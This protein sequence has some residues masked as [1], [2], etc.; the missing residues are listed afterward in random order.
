M[1]GFIGLLSASP[2]GKPDWESE[3]RRAAEEAE[4]QLRPAAER[5]PLPESLTRWAPSLEQLEKLS[6]ALMSPAALVSLISQPELRTAA[7]HVTSVVVELCRRAE[8]SL[9]ARAGALGAEALEEAGSQVVRWRDVAWRLERD[10]LPNL[11]KVQGLVAAGAAGAASRKALLEASRMNVLLNNLDRLEVRGRDSAGL[12]LLVTFPDAEQLAHFEGGLG[13]ALREE[14]HRRCSLQDFIGGAVVRAAGSPS[15]SASLGFTLKVAREVGALGD[16]VAELRTQIRQDSL[17]WSALAHPRTHLNPLAHTR[18]ASNGVI[19][20]ANC[21]PQDNAV[22]SPDGAVVFAGGVPLVAAVLNGDLDNFQQL[23]RT[24]EQETGLSLPPSSTTDAKLIPVMVAHYLEQAGGDLAEAFRRAVGRFEGS[25]AIALHSALEPRKVYLALR[26][27][28]QALFVG[29]SPEGLLYASELYGLVEQTPR[30][31]K[32]EG[33]RVPDSGDR[34]LQGEVAVLSTPRAGAGPELRVAALDGDFTRV[35]SDTIQL[36]EI[37]SR[38]IDRAGYSHYFFKEIHEAPVSIRKTLLGR[39]GLPAPGAKEEPELL[40][41]ASVLSEPVAAALES[42]KL[43]RIYV[44][45]QGTARVAAAGV[46][47]LMR[48]SLAG[49]PIEVRATQA[50]ELS[51]FHLE[52]D[53]ADT[54]VVAVSQ[55]GTTTDTNRTVELLRRRGAHVIAIVNRRNSDLVFKA[56]GVLYTSDGRDVEMAV[57][58]TKAFYCQVVAGHLLGLLVSRLVGCLSE[59]AVT[60]QLKALGELPE[61]LD[62]LLERAEQIRE[63]AATHAVQRPHWAIV[64][65]GPSRVAAEEIRIKLSELC[66]KS[67]S[68]DTIE[69][70]K[71]IDLSSEPL[72]L[73]CCA[74]LPRATLSDLVKEV[75][76][77]QAHRACPIVIAG[78][79]QSG[80]EPYAAGIIRI[81]SV[82]EPLAFILTTMAGHLFGYYAAQ[83]IGQGAEVLRSARAAVEEAQEQEEPDREVWTAMIGRLK[84]VWQ[85]FRRKVGEGVFNAGLGVDTIGRLTSLFGHMLGWLPREQFIEEFSLP[86]SRENVTQLFLAHVTRGI[87]E[88]ARPIDAIRHQAKTVTV[89]VSRPEEFPAGGLFEALSAWEVKPQDLPFPELLLM[90]AIQPAVTEVAGATRYAVSALDAVGEPTE[91]SELRVIEKVGVAETMRSR[92]ELQPTLRGTKRGVV[93]TRSLFFGIGRKDGRPV[94]IIPLTADGRCHQLLLLHVVLKSELT[95]LE[96]VAFLKAFRGRYDDIRHA[97]TELDV[98]WNEELLARLPIEA[99]LFSPPELVAEQAAGM[100]P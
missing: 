25:M 52:P 64:G 68:C 9:E 44:I 76:I 65:S 22:S 66:Y 85:E 48:L 33:E 80:F 59:A 13:P 38:D 6:W 71:H 84:S 1:C 19:S 75:A 90:E 60:R 89:G 41:E 81:P 37:T 67:I 23:A 91:E 49:T 30:F 35:E 28:G 62:R 45:G 15:A 14:L 8:S 58:S 39:I 31:V 97:V 54:L 96:R 4:E 69:D 2:S 7:E 99:L 53:M 32:L 47:Q 11:D 70:K 63:L 27:S 100:A 73:V 50:T 43:R 79:E 42:G 82:S 29:F 51:G 95:L 40:L 87:N 61:R 20:E 56:D 46:A 93:V 17:L 55:S 86:A 21:H 57:A 26:G 94:L 3:L 12:S 72:V 78:D 74:G 92:S 36:A 16:N 10:L 98:P 34:S 88:L 77:F 83:A 24:F 5:E 18:W